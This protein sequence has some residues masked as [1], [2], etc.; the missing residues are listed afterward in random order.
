MVYLYIQNHCFKKQIQYSFDNILKILQIDYCILQS[1]NELLVVNENDILI[2]Y[3]YEENNEYGVFKNILL[4]NDSR[5]IFNK[6]NYLT[7]KSLPTTIQR[8][9]SDNYGE[10]YDI[11]SL[12]NFGE[13]LYINKYLQK[14]K[15]LIE[16]NLDI[17]S[18]IFFMLSRYEEIVNKELIKNEI[19]NRF[20]SK[21]SLAYKNN[22]LHRPI[23]NEHIDLLWSLIDS[24]GLGYKRKNLWGDKDYAA[25]ITHDV[26]MVIKF[27]SVKD[28]IKCSGKLMLKNKDVRGAF[29]LLRS[30]INSKKE[31]KNDPFWTFDY[32][33]DMEKRYGFKSAF[34]FMSGGESKF[35]NFYDINDI[36]VI[37]LI[38]QIQNEGFE[39][40]YHGSFN[41]YNDFELMKKEKEILKNLLINKKYGCR[42]HFLRFEA[43]LTWR[44][45]E[46][47]GLLYD[48][49]LTFAD[50]EGFRCGTC[51]PYKPYDILENRVLDIL[52]IPLIVMEGSLQN[53][54]YSNYSAE[55]GLQ[56]TKELIDTVRK[57]NGVF[58]LLY[59]NSSFDVYNKNWDGWKQT[60]EKTM[61][62]LWST[63]C[64]GGSGRDIINIMGRTIG[65]SNYIE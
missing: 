62:Y 16:T 36:K 46:K 4:I 52:E 57:H 44:Y 24:F 11:I 14:G 53:Q 8:Y 63:N 55:Q 40:G 3:T 28:I 42:Q 26:D 51:L 50:K 23:V 29:Y 33:I 5:I 22:F 39:A 20:S 41:S 43:P 31:Y 6:N 35:D 21:D 2:K 7:K 60:Y 61:E 59:H 54:N 48:T 47:L 64:Y 10:R 30:L 19:F 12:Y 18:D 15:K 9:E 27:K 17:I 37:D 34:Y 56:K 25:C 65:K 58:T 1:L 45:Q 49:T 32:I 38:N 13:R